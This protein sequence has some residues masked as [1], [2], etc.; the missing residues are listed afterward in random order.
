M[1]YRERTI[2]ARRRL[3]KVADYDRYKEE[4]SRNE[5]NT[6]EMHEKI[7]FISPF[8]CIERIYLKEILSYLYNFMLR[9]KSHYS[10]KSIFQ[11]LDLSG[12]SPNIRSKG[13][14]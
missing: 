7:P 8:Y 1:D 3:L 4:Y 11:A 14:H 13:L 9:G 6:L 10:D 5:T 12:S 2:N